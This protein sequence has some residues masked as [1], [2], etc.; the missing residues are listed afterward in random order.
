MEEHQR[1]EEEENERE[2]KNEEE[3]TDG[4]REKGWLTAGDEDD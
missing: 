3:E 1:R 2:C 4:A